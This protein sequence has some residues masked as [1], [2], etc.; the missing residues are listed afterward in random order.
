MAHK[1]IKSLFWVSLR[2]IFHK[3]IIHILHSPA[4]LVFALLFPILETTLL[5][6][7]LD[8]N[9]RYV[10]T[11][12]YDLA[13]TQD[14]RNLI[15]QFAN[16]SDFYIVK[17][18][19]SDKELS[20]AITRGNAKVGIKIPY[21]YSRR[22]NNS[23]TANVLV[24]VDGSNAT[25]TGE[26]VSTA[27]RIALQASIKQ[28]I[29][30][31]QPNG[32][33]VPIETRSAVLFNPDTRSA[34]F[35]LPG[36]LVWE[37]PAITIVLVALSIVKE[38]E[39]GTLDQLRMT[40]INPLGAVIG[41]IAPYAILALLLELEMLLTS[42]YIFS[43]PINGSLGLLILLFIPFI[44]TD[45]GLGVIVAGFAE[46]QKTAL[47]LS[48]MLRVIPPFYLSGYI[49]QIE[50]MPEIVQSVTKF[51]PHRYAIEIVRGILL[52]GAG[53]QHL[54]RHGLILTLMA[55]L[56]LTLAAFIYKYRVIK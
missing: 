47:Q 32:T 15:D 7:I 26:M 6:Y 42:Y 54:W 16:T 24:V 29:A 34:N 19:N 55:I 17:Q 10:N 49:F 18:V 31:R 38:K 48:V 28:L 14:S 11:V 1:G 43:M 4:V 40:P 25:V 30:Q 5:G 23:E 3:E 51:V 9:P 20:D 21:D 2:A 39:Q 8:L 41:K 56:M 50:N 33:E 12:V 13:Q 35:F 53:W 27:N 52:R 37:L 44:F 45:L 22:L 36:L 46:D